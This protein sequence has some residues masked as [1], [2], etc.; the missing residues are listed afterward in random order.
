MSCRQS[1]GGKSLRWGGL[2]LRPANFRKL[3]TTPNVCAHSRL[4]FLFCPLGASYFVQLMKQV[5][6]ME[7]KHYCSHAYLPYGRRESVI[8]PAIAAPNKLNTVGFS[9]INH[10]HDQTN[11]FMSVCKKAAADASMQLVPN[12]AKIICKQHILLSCFS[13]SC[14]DGQLFFLEAVV[15]CLA[16][17]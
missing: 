6:H 9:C 11:A 5:D 10:G 15:F 1:T 2:L 17:L 13:L 12:S 7:H 3:Q 14:P 16:V 4:V 8:L